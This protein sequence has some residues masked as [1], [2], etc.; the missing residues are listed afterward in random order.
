MVIFE[1][2][3]FIWHSCSESFKL[4]ADLFDEILYQLPTYALD[5]DHI[6]YR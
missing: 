3:N 4:F 5:D 1:F 6:D 2:D